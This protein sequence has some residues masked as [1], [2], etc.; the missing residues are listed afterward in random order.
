MKIGT[1]GTTS[2]ENTYAPPEVVPVGIETGVAMKPRV[3]PP[4]S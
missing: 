1:L 2:T 4:A 3:A